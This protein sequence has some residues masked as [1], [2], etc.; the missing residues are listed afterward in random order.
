M[1]APDGEGGTASASVRVTVTGP[2]VSEAGEEM[3]PEPPI[4]LQMTKR[5]R[6]MG[7]T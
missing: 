6:R 3:A 2:R 5:T 7:R 4:E 1:T